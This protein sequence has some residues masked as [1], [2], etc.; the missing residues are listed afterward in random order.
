MNKIFSAIIIIFSPIFILL[1]IVEISAFDF[2][3]YEKKYRQ[4]NI[5]EVVDKDSEELMVITEDLLNYLRYK[6]SELRLKEEYSER[7]LIHLIDVKFLFQRGFILKRISLIISSIAIIML[8]MK[9]KKYLYN[10]FIY[11]SI[12]YLSSVLVLFIL[13]FIDFDKLFTYFHLVLF[14][15]DYWILDPRKD[16]LIQIFPEGFFVDIFSKITLLFIG[17]MSIIL[18]ISYFTKG[19]RKEWKN[20]LIKIINKL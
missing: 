13:Y 6:D 11:S 5:E 19:E 16:F 12:L 20:Y 7:D 9:N 1:Q 10:S 14:N 15:N 8:H 3:F 18:I 4:Y 17:F 2:K